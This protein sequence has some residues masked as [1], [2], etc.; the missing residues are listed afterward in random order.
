MS[1]KIIFLTVYL[2]AVALL[3]FYYGHYFSDFIHRKGEESSYYLYFLIAT[4][5]LFNFLIWPISVRNLFWILLTPVA[6]IV[7][8]FIIILIFMSA[9]DI[10]GTPRQLIF[11]YGCIYLLIMTVLTIVWNGGTNTH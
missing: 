8:S 1:R 6:N 3:T 5:I 11:T 7:S 10:G 4:N 9:F 2:F